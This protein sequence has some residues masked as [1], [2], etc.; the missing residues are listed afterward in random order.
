MPS[1]RSQRLRQTTAPR[2][3][4]EKSVFP[5]SAANSGFFKGTGF[6]PDKELFPN[7]AGVYASV[8]H[9]HHFQKFFGRRN[10]LVSFILPGQHKK[11]RKHTHEGKFLKD[12]SRENSSLTVFRGSP[13][14]GKPG[15]ER[16]S[17][18][19]SEQVEQLANTPHQT[20]L[21]SA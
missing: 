4:G 11:Q 14:L 21:H 19:F 5:G 18:T 6:S 2:I 1:Q 10:A 9:S 15:E 8:L 16:K 20:P 7:F 12:R 13:H 3:P 17:L